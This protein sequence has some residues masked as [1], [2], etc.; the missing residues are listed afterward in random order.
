VV[1]YT[2]EIVT[3]AEAKTLGLKRYFTGRP[4]PQGHVSQRQTTGGCVMC[5]S[6]KTKKLSTEG[7]HKEKKK[8]YRQSNPEQ[9]RG[10][11]N[12]YY[13]NRKEREAGRAR[14]DTCELCGTGTKLEWDHDHETGLFRGWLCNRCNSVLGR[15]GDDAS[16]LMKLAAY[17]NN[18]GIICEEI[19]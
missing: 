5:A 8:Q 3:R 17:V 16:L 10:Y 2:G 14:P 15:V 19:A 11:T 18:G 4:C 6:E 13:L 7:Y 9:H 1:D 12:K